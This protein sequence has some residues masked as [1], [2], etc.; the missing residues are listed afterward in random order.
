MNVIRTTGGRFHFTGS[1]FESGTGH[2]DMQYGSGKSPGYFIITN[3]PEDGKMYVCAGPKQCV[4]YEKREKDALAK[5][6]Q[7]ESLDLL[8]FSMFLGNGPVQH[9]GAYFLNHPNLRYHNYLIPKNIEVI[10]AIDLSCVNM[11]TIKK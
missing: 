6:I 11:L 8:P 9:A 7:I 10:D 4:P 3:G 1:G 2:I 5:T